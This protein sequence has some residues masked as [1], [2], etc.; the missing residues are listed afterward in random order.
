[1]DGPGPI[2]PEERNDDAQPAT[3]EAAVLLDRAR[4]AGIPIMHIMHAAG[5]GSPY[6]VKGRPPPAGS[7]VSTARTCPRLRCRP[8]A[9]P[10]IGGP[11]RCGGA[12]GRGHPGLVRA[13]PGGAPHRVAESAVLLCA[14]G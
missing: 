8:R 12:E 3:D 2:P 5:A 10:R 6:D 4:T 14:A 11:V 9:W 1:M 7:R 13:R